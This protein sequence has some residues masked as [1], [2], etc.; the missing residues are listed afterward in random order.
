[1]G[2]RMV[3]EIFGY[4]GSALVVISMLMSS[5]VKLRIINT[6]GSVIS[7]IYAMICGAIPLAL[8]NFCL[9]TIN[10]INLYK[11]LRTKQTYDLIVG[12][13]DDAMVT[14]FINRYTED[15]KSYFPD[16]DRDD[17]SG[18]KAYIVCCDG[19]Q[20]GVMLGEEENGT[21]NVMIDYAAPTYR[22]CSVGEYLYSKLPSENIR[23]LRFARTVTDMH[24]SYMRKMGFKKEAEKYVKKLSE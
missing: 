11:L 20:A 13:A 9:I 1:M 19:A 8:M 17:L 16:F 14:Y 5:I 12:K 7:G 4:I 10:G 23:I 2:P 18:K 24:A 15:I 6:I 22:D 21:V 3:I